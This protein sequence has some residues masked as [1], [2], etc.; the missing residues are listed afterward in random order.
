MKTTMLDQILSNEILD[1]TY[2]QVYKNEGMAGV[3][4]MTV[5]ELKDY[6]RKNGEKLKNLIRTGQYIPT[7]YPSI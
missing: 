7:T 6:L 1:T 3:D 4:K 2:H 5:F